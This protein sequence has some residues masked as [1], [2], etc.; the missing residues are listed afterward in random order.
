MSALKPVYDEAFRRALQVV[1]WNVVP[2]AVVRAGIRY[3]LSQRV[4]LVGA[5]RR[6]QP[7]D[8]PGPAALVVG[9][10]ARPP[11]ARLPARWAAAQLPSAAG[12]TGAHSL[13][14]QSTPA[15]GEE[16]QDRLAE[17]VEGL[18]AMP[19]A[20]QV[21]GVAGC[22]AGAS[23][24]RALACCPLPHCRP[25]GCAPSLPSPPHRLRPRTSSTMRC[26]PST[27]LPCW[28]PTS[29]TAPACTAAPTAR[30]RRQRRRCWVGGGG[31]V[32]AWGR[33]GSGPPACCCAAPPH[34]PPAR[35][36]RADLC[37]QRAELRDG[38]QVLELGCGWGSLSLFMAARHPGSTFTAVSN[39]RTQKEFIDKQARWAGLCRTGTDALA[40][41]SAEAG[42]ARTAV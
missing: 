4:K 14:L 18:K 12:Q 22:T 24:A 26:R 32:A 3:L 16:H 11:P 10:N 42:G 29:S 19:V 33:W 7:P 6:L 9:C 20:V 41:R 40:A 23:F 39:S 38:Q 28:G 2:D 34:R 25:P 15:N 21:A 1:E 37:C 36:P 31:R 35:P 5:G 8:L 13:P 27:F 30:W 17:F